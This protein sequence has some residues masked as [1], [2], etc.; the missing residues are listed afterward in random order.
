MCLAEGAEGD[1]IQ[2]LDF[3]RREGERRCG[4]LSRAVEHCLVENPPA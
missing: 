2:K 1:P 4:V 3:Q